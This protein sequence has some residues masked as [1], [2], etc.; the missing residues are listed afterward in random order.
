MTS[1][2]A[3]SIGLLSILVVPRGSVLAAI[4]LMFWCGFMAAGFGLMVNAMMADVG[5]EIRLDQGMER[6]SLLYAV[7]T[8]A[9]KIAAAGAISIT[10]PLLAAFGY[11]AAEGAHNTATALRGLEWAFLSGPIIF[12]TL[13][14]VSIW[15]WKLDAARHA[16]VRE[17]LDARDA[18][19]A[20]AAGN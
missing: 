5:D 20:A 10:F 9:A 6:M 16:D 11:S 1:T 14:G 18:A 17:R 4:P 15:G 2:T 13:G 19:L 3:F 7:L 12:V 8:F